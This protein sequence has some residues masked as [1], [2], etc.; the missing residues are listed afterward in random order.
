MLLHVINM[1]DP[2]AFVNDVNCYYICLICWIS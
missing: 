2:F 1:F